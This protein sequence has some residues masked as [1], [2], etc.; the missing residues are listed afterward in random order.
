[1]LGKEDGEQSVESPIPARV[2]GQ[3]RTLSRDQ[4]PISR[5]EISENALKV[6]YRLNKGGYEA[7]LVGGGVRDLLLGKTPKDFDIAT[8]ATPE[9]IKAEFDYRLQVNELPEKYYEYLGKLGIVSMD[10]LTAAKNFDYY[11]RMLKEFK[12]DHQMGVYRM[13]G[14]LSIGTAF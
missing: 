2:A 9:Q 11:Q 14:A 3:R 13:S 7:Y 8:D 6:L 10:E 4:H 5:K 12:T 1:V